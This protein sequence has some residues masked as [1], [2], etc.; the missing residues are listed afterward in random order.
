MAS[1]KTHRLVN[2]PKMSIGKLAE[3]LCASDRKRRAIL[4]D[5][6]YRPLARIVQH[7]EAKLSIAGAFASRNVNQSYFV[8]EADR[9]RSKIADTAF[10][11]EENEHNADYLI[12]FSKVI[13]SISLPQGE[14]LIAG[15]RL[16]FTTHGVDLSADLVFRLRRLTKTNKVK[17]GAAMLRYTKG[18]QTKPEICVTQAS[19]MFG[20]LSLPEFLTEPSAEAD[21]ALCIVIDA[22]T[23]A[24][25]PAAGDSASRFANAEAA[26]ELISN[27]WEGIQ[28]PKGAIF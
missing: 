6:K 12:N 2:K 14:V 27:A 11:T 5:S 15:P 23:G 25:H 10:E 28:P 1:D 3:Y 16:L 21:R 22:Y 17:I 9:I 18:K 4:R 13:D 26:C 24:I 20:A 8:S 7:N 19:L